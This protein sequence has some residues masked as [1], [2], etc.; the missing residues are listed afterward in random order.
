ML[1]RDNI[2]VSGVAVGIPA[3]SGGLGASLVGASNVASSAASAAQSLTEDATREQ[4]PAPIAEAA[5]GWL[6]V[7]VEGF[8]ADVCKAGDAACLQR[9]GPPN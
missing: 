6:E 5:L 7:F 1:G 2:Q 9:Q 8:G 4:G 3:D